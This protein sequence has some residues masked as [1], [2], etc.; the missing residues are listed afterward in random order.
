MPVGWV[1]LPSTAAATPAALL[2]RTWL[3][4]L[5]HLFSAAA[6]TSVVGVLAGQGHPAALVLS[7]YQYA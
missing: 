3:A 6:C 4:I 1:A 7:G 5:P 2:L